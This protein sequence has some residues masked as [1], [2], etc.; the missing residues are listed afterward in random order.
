MKV[1]VVGSGAREHA[2]VWKLA[3]ETS[4]ERVICAPGN[5]GIEDI[6]SCQ[7]IDSMAVPALVELA[8][9]ERID[10]TVV[11]PEQPLER[12]I[13]DAFATAGLPLFGP[14]QSAA[15]L[16][17]SKAFAKQFMMRHG[18]PTARGIICRKPGEANDAVAELGLPVAIKADGLAAGKGVTIA[19]DHETARVA[20]AAAM[21]SHQFGEAGRTLVVEEFLSGTEVSCFALCDGERALPLVAAQD[22][23]RLFD[24]DR[25]PNT[26]GMGAFA[27]S[28]L[29][30]EEVQG[31][32]TR[33][34][35]RRV[36][37]GMAHEGTPFRGVLYCGL[38]LTAEGPKV[39]EFNV[40]LGDP[41]AQVILPLMEAD[42][43]PL[44]RDAA[45]GELSATAVPVKS[46]VQVGVVL[47]SRGYPGQAEVGLPISGV[48]YPPGDILV[49]HA[50][51]RH[52]GGRI[53]TAGGRVLTVVAGGP[54]FSTAIQQ[55]YEG[56]GQIS[57]PGMQWRRDIGRKAL[58]GT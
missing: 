55:V 56:V 3:R 42:L 51:T 26:G 4:V 5:P 17:T 7:A 18:I 41:E 43:A 22:H 52:A 32:V 50:G 47:A 21:V 39:V 30:T 53:V 23:K 20:I 37:E 46:G 15:R 13:A 40:R 38:M 49:F 48:E 33:T 24:H 35:V 57:F 12:G 58:A 44:M 16:E 8:R 1:L 19:T 11:G 2:L 10:L 45:A 34:I 9:R 27:P 29:V 31:T 25:G 54:D 28:P 14:T 6:A 36:V